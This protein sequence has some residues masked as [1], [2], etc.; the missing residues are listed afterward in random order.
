MVIGMLLLITGE[1]VEDLNYK[2]HYKS[3][4]SDGD[5]CGNGLSLEKDDNKECPRDE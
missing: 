4:E 3:C 5:S 1:Y 2:E